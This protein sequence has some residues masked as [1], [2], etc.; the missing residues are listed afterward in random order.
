LS[1]NSE[2]EPTIL[3]TYDRQRNQD[4][5]ITGDIRIESDYELRYTHMLETTQYGDIG[6]RST[7][8]SLSSYA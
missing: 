4:V 3:E 2:A 8:I 6:L 7:T 5:T 1:Q